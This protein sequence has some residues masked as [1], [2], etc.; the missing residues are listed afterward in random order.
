[1]IT[2]VFIPGTQDLSEPF[3]IRR[4]VF[5]QEQNCP[6]E[7]DFDGLDEQALHLVV[8]MD[9][10]P[11]ATGRIWHDGSDFRIGRLAVLKPYRGQ[12]LGDLALRLLLYKAFS[13]GAQSI[14]ISAQTYLI[15]FYRKFGFREIGD[16]YTEAGLP[17]VAMRVTK[18]QVVYPS[19]CCAHV[20]QTQE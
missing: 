12:K 16:E 18:D 20:K 15:A 4:S 2:S 13:T 5:I 3:G 8:Y 17:H 10:Q 7:I 9:E 14:K 11:A 6:E 1:M 19:A